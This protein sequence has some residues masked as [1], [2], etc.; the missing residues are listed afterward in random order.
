MG[1]LALS[2]SYYQGN[3]SNL[4]V[5]LNLYKK[6]HSCLLVLNMNMIHF[7]V[8]LGYSMF[9]VYPLDCS[10]CPGADSIFFASLFV[11]FLKHT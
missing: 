5:F 2:D 8:E 1:Q 6:C 10:W 4:K 11:S 9:L 7:F 3:I